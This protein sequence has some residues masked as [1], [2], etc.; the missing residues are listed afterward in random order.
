MKCSSSRLEFLGCVG[1]ALAAACAGAGAQEQPTLHTNEAY[2]EEAMRPTKLAVDDPMAVFAFVFERLPDRVQVYPTENYY[3]FTFIHDG[4]P[5]DGNIRLDASTRDQGKVDFAYSEDLQ[6]WRDETPVLHLL[7]DASMGVTVD[8]L[9]RLV[10]R[11]SFKQKSVVFALNDLSQVKPPANALA[12]DETFIGPVFDESAIRF[13][14]VYNPK[15]K[16]FHYVLDETV[17]VPDAFVPA[18]RTDRILIGTRTGFA[19]YRD[20]R[21]DRKIMIGAFEG[22]IQVNNY[23]D[24]PFDQ[25]PDNFIEGETFRNILIEVEP[26]LAGKIDR[27]GGSPDGSQRYA[28]QPYLSYRTEED[29]HI[30]DKCANKAKVTPTYYNCFVMDYDEQGRP[31]LR[32][33]VLAKRSNKS[34]KRGAGK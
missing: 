4:K 22:N 26:G 12:P 23:F 11:I 8:K 24:G 15:L 14:L 10:Y 32:S 18:R 6:E 34:N 13:F 33:Q 30:F 16:I 27:F 20:H 3:Y 5:Y 28:I 29:L 2:V 7:L 21:R 9:D 17:K 19:F 1:L 25:L 31:H